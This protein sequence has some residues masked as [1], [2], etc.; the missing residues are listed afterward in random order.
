M[1]K[2][3]RLIIYPVLLLALFTAVTGVAPIRSSP[4]IIER[5]VAREVVI[6]SDYGNEVLRL[7][8]TNL[9]GAFDL[10]NNFGNAVVSMAILDAGSGSPTAADGRITQVVVK[11]PW[12][13]AV[14]QRNFGVFLNAKGNYDEEYYDYAVHLGMRWRQWAFQGASLNYVHGDGARLQ[15]DPTADQ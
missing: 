6:M 14:D 13:Y 15:L 11:Q 10:Y 7:G 5:I 1:S 8:S 12:P 2:Y 9:G 4:E 3:E